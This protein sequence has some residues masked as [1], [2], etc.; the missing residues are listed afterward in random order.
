MVPAGGDEKVVKTKE[1]D[2]EGLV[3]EFVD[4]V[5]RFEVRRRDQLLRI[6]G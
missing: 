2:G 3:E 5:E 4:G 1:N 6:L